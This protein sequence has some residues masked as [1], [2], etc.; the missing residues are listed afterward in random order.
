MHRVLAYKQGKDV[1]ASLAGCLGRVGLHPCIKPLKPPFKAPPNLDIPF[2]IR[3]RMGCVLLSHSSL[4]RLKPLPFKFTCSCCG[5]TLLETEN[6]MCRYDS[7]LRPIEEFVRR[8]I[9]EK[10]P[11]CGHKLQI[12]PVKIEVYPLKENLKLQLIAHHDANAL[13]RKKR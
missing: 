4:R 2:T 3:L 7:R 9:G 10:C 11:F 12:P 6:L 13:S 5:K 1:Q 8:R